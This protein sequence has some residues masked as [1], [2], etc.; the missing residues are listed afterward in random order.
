V[1][2]TSRARSNLAV[3]GNRL[4][5]H[6]GLCEI[7]TVAREVVETITSTNLGHDQNVIPARSWHHRWEKIRYV[8]LIVCAHP[9]CH[10]KF[11]QL[12]PDS[13]SDQGQ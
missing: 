11:V 5:I 6:S 2:H 7:S 4:L 12:R 1:T 8:M 13:D 3:A 9:L 10:T